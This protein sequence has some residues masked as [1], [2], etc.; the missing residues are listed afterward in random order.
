MIKIKNENTKNA[1]LKL[2]WAKFGFGDEILGWVFIGEH[3]HK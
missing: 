2:V 3:K 1:L